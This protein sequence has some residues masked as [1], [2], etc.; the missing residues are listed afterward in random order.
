M[1]GARLLLVC[2]VLA[3]AAVS[4]PGNA[5]GFLRG[6]HDHNS[7]VKAVQPTWVT[8]L[9]GTTPL[10]GQFVREEFVRQKMPGGAA[11]WN[12]GNN[13]GLSLILSRRVETDLSMPNYVVHGSAPGTDGVG[14]FCFTTR[15]RIASGDREHG[16]YSVAAVLSQTWATGLEKNGAATWTRGITMAG[17]KA[18]GR[19]AALGSVGA[20]IPADAGLATMGRPVA[21]NSAFE[22]HMIPKVWAQV[23]SNTTYYNGGAHDGK[24]Q[25]FVTPGV[26]LVPLKWS[27]ASKSYVLLGV[28]M[29]FATTRYHSSDH[30]LVVDTKIYF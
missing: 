2:A 16:N 12:I 30:N 13:K 23:E 18:F 28:G 17:G 9:V 29:Q 25:T 24:V 10:L 4:L 7:E 22:M 11:V 5:Q 27:A 8:P 19:F 14:D 15:V 21:M 20:T 6:F 1:R 3:A 26:F